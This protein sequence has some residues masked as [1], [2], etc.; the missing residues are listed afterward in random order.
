MFYRKNS[1][2]WL[3]KA[4]GLKHT[5]GKVPMDYS[6]IELGGVI[7]A[8]LEGTGVVLEP[9][10]PIK[11]MCR[12]FVEVNPKLF[13]YG[14][15][16]HPTVLEPEDTVG[17]LVRCDRTDLEKFIEDGNWVFRIYIAR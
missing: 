5:D 6:H 10:V 11:V 9:D 16:N 3:M 4:T 12:L 13:M 2:N 15:C 1:G 8:D 17:A 7:A 14:S